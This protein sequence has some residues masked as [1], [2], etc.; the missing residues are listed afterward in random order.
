MRNRAAVGSPHPWV[1]T[2][3]SR[4]CAPSSACAWCYAPSRSESLARPM[5]RFLRMLAQT[6]IGAEPEPH[7][8]G[9]GEPPHENEYAVD[10]TGGGMFLLMCLA[11]GLLTRNILAP[12]LPFP[13]TVRTKSPRRAT[14]SIALVVQH[15]ALAL[16][17]LAMPET[18]QPY[19]ALG[20]CLFCFAAGMPG[21]Q[22]LGAKQAARSWNPSAAR[23]APHPTPTRRC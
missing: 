18:L 13:Y 17:H 11:I 12:K 8:G 10:K 3:S 21:D 1:E 7:G 20:H 16:V 2:H 19:S 22:P 9:G 23:K 5:L 14:P 4:S 15:P 6:R